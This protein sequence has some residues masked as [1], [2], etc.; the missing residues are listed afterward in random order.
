MSNAEPS[1]AVDADILR[2]RLATQMV[3]PVRW[4]E[5]MGALAELDVTT[6][7]EAGPGSVLTGLTRR[8]DGLTGTAVEE[9]GV[10]AVMEEVARS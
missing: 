9:S 7:I 10:D 8:V 6:L 3:S 5:T 1:P 4:T 2:H